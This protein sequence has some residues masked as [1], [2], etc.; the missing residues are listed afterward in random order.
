[1]QKW[2]NLHQ[3]PWWLQVYLCEWVDRSKLLSQHRRLSNWTVLQR[4]NVPRSSRLLLLRVPTR[5]NRYASPLPMQVPEKSLAYTAEP[6]YNNRIR[7]NKLNGNPLY[8]FVVDL[9]EAF[10]SLLCLPES[11]NLMMKHDIL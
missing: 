4:W 7:E 8:L 6:F 2:G 3:Q 5:E 9:F 10:E 1:M 11:G